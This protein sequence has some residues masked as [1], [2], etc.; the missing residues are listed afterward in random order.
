LEV[1]SDRIDNF[2]LKGFHWWLLFIC[3]AGSFFDF[4][5]QGS[6]MYVL[7]ILAKKFT[8]DPVATANIATA[9]AIGGLAGVLTCGY[10]SDLYGRRTM[11]YYDLIAF[12]IT[13]LMTPY[14]PDYTWLLIFR[15]L[16]GFALAG[17]ILISTVY[18]AEFIP[19][20][21]RGKFIYFVSA[22]PAMGFI[23]VGFASAALIPIYGWTILF[24]IGG[25]FAFFTFVIR[26]TVPE[27]PRFLAIRGKFK[28]ATDIVDKMSRKFYNRE[29]EPWPAAIPLKTK[30]QT[31]SIK[32]LFAGIY[33]KRMIYLIFAG[34]GDGAC[35]VVVITLRVYALTYF[36]VPYM[37]AVGISAYTTVFSLLGY[38]FGGPLVDKFGRRWTVPAE[39]FV[40]S[41]SI[42]A[43]GYFAMPTLNF[44]VL[45]G[46]AAPMEILQNLQRG[47]QG[48]WKVELFPTRVRATAKSV[49]SLG[50][51]FAGITMATFGGFIIAGFGAQTLYAVFAVITA[52]AFAFPLVMGDETKG[53]KLE[54]ISPDIWAPEYEKPIEK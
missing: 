8:L 49:N 4:W 6:I 20:K 53:K 2:P 46:F 21:H 42:F 14:A 17:E 19:L 12:S 32:D 22:G 41:A 24:Y 5:D 1:L 7:P 13:T 9:A 28:Q 25:A 31:M 51:T 27:S 44:W 29:P 36:G 38:F 37:T 33:T 11:M 43:F 50:S 54:V 48:V 35:Q 34:F 45:L 52:A 3:A 10:L 47:G 30:P 15:G 40:L 16:C 26:F 23:A 18:M 39:M